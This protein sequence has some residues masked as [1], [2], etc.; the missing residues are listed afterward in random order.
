MFYSSSVFQDLSSIFTIHKL[1]RDKGDLGVTN[2]LLSDGQNTP[3]KTHMFQKYL[4]QAVGNLFT[5]NAKGGWCGLYH[6]IL[7]ILTPLCFY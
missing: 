2:D 1:F 4:K 5:L 6:F 3:K 7:K